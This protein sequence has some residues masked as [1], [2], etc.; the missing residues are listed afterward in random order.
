MNADHRQGLYE[1]TPGKYFTFIFCIQNK[2]NNVLKYVYYVGCPNNKTFSRNFSN[3]LSL[4][5][6]RNTEKSMNENETGIKFDS[7]IGKKKSDRI[8]KRV[9]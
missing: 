4:N 5:S 6:H 1:L 9:Q 2:S 7:V 8:S 3:F